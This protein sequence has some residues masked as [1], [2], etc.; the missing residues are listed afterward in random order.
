MLGPTS[1]VNIFEVA[2]GESERLSPLSAKNYLF[3]GIQ[4]KVAFNLN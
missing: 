1:G 4:V 3:A 2:V